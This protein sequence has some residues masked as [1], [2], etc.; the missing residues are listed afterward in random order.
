ML[1]CTRTVSL[2]PPSATFVIKGT[3]SRDGLDFF[4]FTC[5][6]RLSYGKA[7]QQIFIFFGAPRIFEKKSNFFAFSVSVIRKLGNIK[8]I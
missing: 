4:F 6:D 7:F 2:L 1:E 5:V 8:Y 3:V